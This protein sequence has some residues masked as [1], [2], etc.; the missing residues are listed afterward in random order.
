M[1][2]GHQ[3][4]VPRH[5]ARLVG[6]QAVVRGAGSKSRRKLDCQKTGIVYNFKNKIFLKIFFKNILP[7]IPIP[8][9]TNL[10]QSDLLVDHRTTLKANSGAKIGVN[11]SG[12][13]QLGRHTQPRVQGADARAQ[14]YTLLRSQGLLG[15]PGRHQSSPADAGTAGRAAAECAWQMT[16]AAA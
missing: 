8:T 10:S 2:I 6:R 4:R 3:V 9:G 16:A 13:R 15:P 7:R 1:P 5:A 11:W 14:D 12:C